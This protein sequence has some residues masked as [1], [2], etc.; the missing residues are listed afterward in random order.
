MLL[1]H[2]SEARAA[3]VETRLWSSVFYGTI[4][5]LRAKLQRYDTETKAALAKGAKID[6]AIVDR[7]REMYCS[8]LEDATNFYKGLIVRLQHLYGDVGMSLIPLR[9]PQNMNSNHPNITSTIGLRSILSPP[10]LGI[11][12]KD[13]A[14]IPL[15]DISGLSDA[16]RASA[17]DPRALCYR[18]L[19]SM[20]D[21]VRYKEAASASEH[22]DYKRVRK[23]YLR[24][25]RILPPVDSAYNQLAVVSVH[26]NDALMSAYYLQR[27]LL[28]PGTAE[29]PAQFQATADENL[30]SL[31]LKRSEAV[32]KAYGKGQPPPRSSNTA[33]KTRAGAFAMRAEIAEM[34]VDTWCLPWA[35]H[36]GRCAGATLEII[37][38]FRTTLERHGRQLGVFLEAQEHVLD[39]VVSQEILKDPRTPV[40]SPLLDSIFYSASV[41]AFTALELLQ[42]RA[43][44]SLATCLA[45]T[46]AFGQAH[47][48]IGRVSEYY[49]G[50]VEDAHVMPS[51]HLTL[52][53]LAARPHFLLPVIAPGA[54]A[55]AAVAEDLTAKACCV[56]D[57]T[58]LLRLLANNV[59][60][61]EEGAAEYAP[62][63]DIVYGEVWELAGCAW[64]SGQPLDP[65][66]SPSVP[67]SHRAPDTAKGAGTRA[68]NA[69]DAVS[70]AQNGCL[71]L[72]GDRKERR[73][74]MA[75]IVLTCARLVSARE[76]QGLPRR[77]GELEAGAAGDEKVRLAA[78]EYRAAMSIFARD[79]RRAL[80]TIG[81]SDALA[82]A[83]APDAFAEDYEGGG[84]G[85]GDDYMGDDAPQQVQ[86][87]QQREASPP[88]QQSTAVDQ[89]EEMEEEVVLRTFSRSRISPPG[90]AGASR[91]PSGRFSVPRSAPAEPAPQ[92]APAP[93]RAQED[94]LDAFEMTLNRQQRATA[95]PP[96]T[97]F[98]FLLQQAE[99]GVGSTAASTPPARTGSANDLRPPRPRH[100]FFDS[101]EAPTAAGPTANQT[102]PLHAPGTFDPFSSG[103]APLYQV[104]TSPLRPSPAPLPGHLSGGRAPS[105]PDLHGLGENALPPRRSS[106]PWR[107]PAYPGVQEPFFESLFGGVGAAGPPA[108]AREASE[109]AWDAGLPSSSMYGQGVAPMPHGGGFFG[110]GAGSV[111][112]AVGQPVA[113]PDRQAPWPS[114]AVPAPQPP[115]PSGGK[116][117]AAAAQK[118]AFDELIDELFAGAEPSQPPDPSS[119]IRTANP[120]F[121]HY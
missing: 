29:I 94:W 98:N 67:A 83:G 58:R 17:G 109:G 59:A 74:R 55:T 77:L 62:A 64:L 76:V 28:A 42:T 95:A 12:F 5:G 10:L 3:R 121:Q 114:A 35:L 18:S 60:V 44:G 104:P 53:W 50:L 73:A 90:S 49:R 70:A 117:A 86:P 91:P 22:K 15:P 97:V 20:G 16:A 37:T 85:G 96:D 14:K 47:R 38:A 31:V 34:F 6:R 87:P 57:L 120:F 102:T 8:F 78:Q 40:D 79:T 110:T 56:Q 63:T 24:A 113:P 65:G 111:F 66:P 101:D 84:A 11:T 19:I 93:D 52:L 81:Q 68:A 2:P 106:S 1:F 61:S 99:G 107:A 7:L 115:Q 75:S 71:V 92:P 26:M 27:T 46:L 32:I 69:R 9:A 112:G 118:L 103:P 82:A 119:A 51:I 108:H 23:F 45:S 88:Q 89:D 33:P 36:S 21:L 54:D 105:F 116:A 41:V 13:A 25:A 100:S 80:A 72:L 39:A 30:Q 43:P 4:S 48:I